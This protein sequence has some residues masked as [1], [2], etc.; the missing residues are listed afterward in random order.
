MGLAMVLIWEGMGGDGVT[1]AGF[2]LIFFHMMIS[3]SYS[4]NANDTASY[5]VGTAVTWLKPRVRNV[6]SAIPQAYKRS[7][8]IMDGALPYMYL[9][10][11]NL[12]K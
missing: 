5:L 7:P 9:C 8:K 1:A 10:S 4:R 2:F 6:S 3:H 12:L 11:D